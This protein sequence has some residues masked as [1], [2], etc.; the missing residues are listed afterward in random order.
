[1]RRHAI[2]R[3]I[4]IAAIVVLAC[5]AWAESVTVHIVDADGKPVAGATV[6]KLVGGA[7]IK[8]Q[9]LM[10]A[11]PVTIGVTD[12]GG[13]IRL[14]CDP[15]ERSAFLVEAL[16][17]SPRTFG[18]W[19]CIPPSYV[20]TLPRSSATYSGRIAD[21][22][23]KSV[24][25]AAVRVRVN[26]YP[27]LEF[28]RVFSPD[29]P[30]I[31]YDLDSR[32]NA[33]GRFSMVAPRE[34][35][36]AAIEVKRDGAWHSAMPSDWAVDAVA[37]ALR[38]GSFVGRADPVAITPSVP[39]AT[40][41]AVVQTLAIHLRVFDASTNRPIE[42]IRVIPGGCR[43]PDQPFHTLWSNVL[44]L[45]GNEATW[46]F[47]DNSWAY[48]LRVEADGYAAAPTRIVKA[49]EKDADVEVRLIRAKQLSLAVRTPSGRPAAGARAYLSTPTIA[50]NVPMLDRAVDHPQ[51]I[52]MA[53]D[54][55]VIRFVPPNETYRLAI[56]H[57]EGWAEISGTDLGDKPLVLERWA[58]ADIRLG[59]TKNPLRH[60]FIETQS[61][62]SEQLHCPI[63]WL[64][65]YN[66]NVQGCATVA[67]CR[68][69]GVHTAVMLMPAVEAAVGWSYLEIQHAIKPGQH[70]DLPVMT[71]ATTVRAFLPEFPGCR[72][73]MLWINPAGPAAEL[74][75][76]VNRLSGKAQT[77]AVEKAQQAAPD[78]HA[79]EDVV[80]ELQLPVPHDG[81]L[82][83]AG[84]RPGTY[85][86]GGYVEIPPGHQVAY[87]LNW[88][89]SVPASAPALVD[90]GTVSPVPAD[91]NALRIGQST[92]DLV[93]T[94]LDGKRFS[95]KSR[96]GHWVLLDFWGTW[97]GFCIAEEPTLK[98]AYEG[99]SREGRLA[100]VSVSVDDTVEQVRRH[101]ADNKL[102]WTQLILGPRGQTN[103]PEA[104][105]VDGY[106]WI[107][108]ISPRGELI[109]TG[110]RGES[111]R[112]ALMKYLGP[113]APPQPDAK[114][115]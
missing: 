91:P 7:F 38:D 100:M 19:G 97:C 98:D 3:P 11:M 106:P 46:K 110:L 88:Y 79:E 72:W 52:A 51:P 92:P 112:D 65:F 85:V 73:S 42:N 96:L 43:S 17:T 81:R 28:A 33:D 89:F 23:G 14:D 10:E 64:G 2:C 75:A 49:S 12:A 25:N 61:I 67:H 62:I 37:S 9:F 31:G 36:L 78:P 84:L 44:D 104:F 35:S 69:G 113:P 80:G 5:R 20:L 21:A 107:M 4:I 101:V 102:P 60:Q 114:E 57:G 15:S 66:S 39:P 76:D 50:L 22:A 32:T 95:L 111:V 26:S 82:S 109:E 6:S 74:P 83:V 115:R 58:S 53:G 56:E 16:G 68:P 94:T 41:P 90:L 103:V 55:G 54:D 1:M 8:S 27:L 71:G 99:W 29:Y 18:F 108:L 13:T 40:R 86:L 63:A 105:G 47:Y 93:A 34:G 70:V 87:T 59:S 24:A 77:A 30:R 45:P 48:F